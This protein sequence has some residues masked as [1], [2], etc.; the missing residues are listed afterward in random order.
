MVPHGIE[1]QPI[2]RA[3]FCFG[4]RF[5]HLQPKSDGFVGRP[6]HAMLS[7]RISEP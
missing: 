5:T 2:P 1:V 3:N 6:I 4:F 7:L